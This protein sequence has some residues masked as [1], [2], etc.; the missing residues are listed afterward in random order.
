MTSPVADPLR[1]ADRPL[2]SDH[3]GLVAAVALSVLASGAG[4]ALMGVS[5]WLLSRAAEH[6]PVLYLLIAIVGV[7]AFGLTRG[8]FRY[9][10]RLVGHRVALRAQAD[11][12]VQ[13]YTALARSTWVGRRS[14]DLL[15]RVVNDVEAVQDLVVRV[16]VPIASAGV[17]VVA[18]TTVLSV[19]S[20]AAGAVIGLSAA[21][22]AVVL[23]WLAG[24]WSRSA[25]AQL[26]PLRGELADVV[27]E[28][29]DAAA[30]IIACG[31]QAS[32]LE[33]VR[34]VDEQLRRAEARTAFVLGLASAGQVL[35]AGVAILG[36]LVLGG[37]AVAAGTLAPVY[38]AVLVLTP[39]ALHE[40]LAGLPT[41][42]QTRSRALAALARV[43]ALLDAEPVGRGDLVTVAPNGV[44][45]DGVVS[46]GV[47][48]SSNNPDTDAQDTSEP[49]THD[50]H[51]T[52]AGPARIVARGLTAGW[53]GRPAVVTDLDLDVTAGERVAL[54][55]PSGIGK[56]AVAATLLGLLEPRAGSVD[57]SG[58]LG[59]LEQ[60]AYLF[61]T[62]VAENVR[63]GHRDASDAEV[64]Q[65]CA[66]V[67]LDLA[68]DRLV[69]E[70][71]GHVSGGEARR[72]ALARVIVGD[73][74]VLILDEPTEHLDRPT[75]D[76]LMDDVWAITA[77]AA[78]LVIT[79]DQA[80]M[81][82][83]DRLVTL[84]VSETTTPGALVASAL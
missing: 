17:V 76:A 80:V 21:L 26:A 16:V 53:P 66:R 5:A 15:S 70:H 37:R 44:V 50:Q 12:R 32:Q 25:D 74:S 19:L 6:P 77:D 58:S 24:R 83:C 29:G 39:I 82:R 69:G 28:V 72:I 27:V 84:G 22:G 9:L 8:V 65:A 48:P 52:S 23:P 54:V 56:T 61:D 34:V 46:H 33:R 71:G 13:T 73:R 55:G 31:A 1:S 47:R 62:T 78:V 38:L 7:R 59:Y 79:H 63:I 42:V 49:S 45:S 40:V 20:P 64:A 68:P 41:A 81:A 14:G 11:L 18:T 43:R 30:D 57:V 10:E 2:V 36:G 35:A 4:I 51:A 60:D 67:G 3:R 75:A